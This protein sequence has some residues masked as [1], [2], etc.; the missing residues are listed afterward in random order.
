MSDIGFASFNFPGILARLTDAAQGDWSEIDGP[1]SGCGVDY[2]YAGPAG[3]QAYVNFDQVVLSVSITNEAAD[4]EPTRFEFDFDELEDGH[5]LR[6]FIE[7]S[8]PVPFAS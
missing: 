6:S 7:T 4:K 1:S 8:G 3:D 5:W 2:W